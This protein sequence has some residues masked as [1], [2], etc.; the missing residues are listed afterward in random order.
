[1]EQETVTTI[2]INGDMS[3]GGVREQ[4]SLLSS[5]LETLPGN[6]T[7]SAR[8]TLD[9]S[10]VQALD[11]CGCQLL[12]AFYHSLSERGATIC[13]LIVNDDYRDKIR[14]LGFDTELYA[15]NCA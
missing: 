3:M 12:A 13:S 7:E 8:C 14:T 11:A 5:H 4:F 10:G 1:M 15:G 6:D 9:L 2:S